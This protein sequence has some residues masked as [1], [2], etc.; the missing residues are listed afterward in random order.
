LPINLIIIIIM[1]LKFTFLL[2]FLCIGFSNYAQQRTCDYAQRMQE[3]LQD[4]EFRAN[5]EARQ[6]AFQLEYERLLANPQERLQTIFIPVAAHYPD[7][8]EANRACLE[9]LARDQ[10]RI[11][12]ED[13]LG[14]NA[15]ISVWEA[16]SSEYPGVNSGAIDVQFVLATQNHP[17]GVDPDIVEGGPAVTVGNAVSDTDARWAGYQNFV[18]KDLG[19]GILGYSPLGGQPGQ[20]DSVVQNTFAFGSGSGCPGFVPQAPFNLGRTVTHELGHHYN[21][22]HTWGNGG[23]GSDDGVTD[24]PNIDEPTYGCVAPGSVTMCGN[25]SLTTNFMDYVDD[26]CMVMFTEGQAIRMNAYINTIKDDWKDDVLSVDSFAINK[27]YSIYPNPAN[28][29]LHISLISNAV[30]EASYVVYDIVGKTVFKGDLSLDNN[31]QSRKINTSELANGVY[32]LKINSGK[33]SATKKI[34]VKH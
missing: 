30:R 26:R 15:D 7:G 10:I 8:D 5:Y 33:V 17:F 16:A 23:C 6:A 14:T 34:V 29:E 21:L 32:L 28:E 11:L 1:K 25:K 20:G 13:F 3:K 9:D 19:G 22:D 12:N 24:T 31:I 2:A 4:P 18:I 27:V